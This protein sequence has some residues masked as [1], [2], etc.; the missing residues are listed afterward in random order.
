MCTHKRYL[1]SPT[2][3]ATS[4]C[5]LAIMDVGNQ[6]WV[7]LQSSGKQQV[8]LTTEPI[9]QVFLN[10]TITRFRLSGTNTETQ[11]LGRLK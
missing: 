9:L 2:I 4:T 3:G 8:L 10:K 11:L 6:I 5:N 7:G 1:R